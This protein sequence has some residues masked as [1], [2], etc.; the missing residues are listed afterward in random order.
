MTVIASAND[1]AVVEGVEGEV[2]DPGAVDQDGRDAVRNSAGLRSLEHGN[3]AAGSGERQGDAVG[4]GYE[5]IRVNLRFPLKLNR[6]SSLIPSHYSS[7]AQGGQDV[8]TTK[9]I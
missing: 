5:V 6:K 3:F 1:A 8:L 7:L 9:R 2:H 4:V